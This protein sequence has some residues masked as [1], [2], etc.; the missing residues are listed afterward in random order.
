MAVEAGVTAVA[1]EEEAE[2]AEVLAVVVLVLGR[3]R[4][5]LKKTS[6]LPGTKP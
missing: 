4:R 5:R 1:V 3:L 6:T 2:V